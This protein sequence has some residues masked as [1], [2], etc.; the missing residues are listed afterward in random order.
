MEKGLSVLGG[1]RF[2]G[3]KA[4]RNIEQSRALGC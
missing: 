2:V 1:L 3:L 4:K